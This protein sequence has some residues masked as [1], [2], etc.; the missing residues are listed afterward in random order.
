MEIKIFDNFLKIEDLEILENLD[1]PL[2]KSDKK[3]S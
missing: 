2:V 3:Y 1:L